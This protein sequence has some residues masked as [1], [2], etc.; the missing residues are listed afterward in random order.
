MSRLT[1]LAD[2]HRQFIEAFL[3]ARGNIRELEK[4]LGIS[5]WYRRWVNWFFVRGFC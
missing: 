3:L 5:K 4:E 2:E 1:L